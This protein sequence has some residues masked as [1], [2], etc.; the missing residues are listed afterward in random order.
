MSVFIDIHVYVIIYETCSCCYLT[1]LVS[2]VLC[3]LMSIAIVPDVATLRNKV[4]GY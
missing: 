4:M 3:N 1:A 2:L